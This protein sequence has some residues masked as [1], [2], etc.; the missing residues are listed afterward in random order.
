[1]LRRHPKRWRLERRLV[2]DGHV[3]PSAD[4]EEPMSAFEILVAALAWLDERGDPRGGFFEV[5]PGDLEREVGWRGKP[6][7]LWSALVAEHWIDHTQGGFVWHDYGAWN[8][9]TLRNRADQRRRRGLVALDEADRR[10]DCVAD[11]QPD[12]AAD[13]RA[14]IEADK[15]TPSGSGSERE[16]Q[17][18]YSPPRGRGRRPDQVAPLGA[19]PESRARD[20]V[21][22]IREFDDPAWREDPNVTPAWVDRVLALAPQV[23]AAREARRAAAWWA[24]KPSRT[25][26][27]KSCTGTLQTFLERAQ[28]GAPESAGPSPPPRTGALERCRAQVEEAELR[29]RERHPTPLGESKP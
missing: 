15:H 4:A 16:E 7:A 21:A 19:F 11:R 14:D 2:R 9:K 3:W 29:R 6:G 12:K 1:M 18:P 13:K 22:A 25:R 17:S 24:S 10:A 20:F 5:E 28:E 26:A 8:G 23:D 27:R